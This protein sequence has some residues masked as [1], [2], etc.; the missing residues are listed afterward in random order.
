MGSQWG[1]NFYIGIKRRIVA[2]LSDVTPGPIVSLDTSIK[3]KIVKEAGW[4][5]T[6][7]FRRKLLFC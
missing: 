3:T 7:Y 6:K 1:F 5:K 2:Q 4:S